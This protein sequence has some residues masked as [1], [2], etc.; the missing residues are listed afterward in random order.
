MNSVYQVAWSS[1]SYYLASASKDSTIKIW[2]VKDPKKPINTLS[3][4]AD[5]VYSIDWSPNGTQVASGSKD[6]LIKIWHH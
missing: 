4:H 1:D 6:H 5:E 3:G 2:S